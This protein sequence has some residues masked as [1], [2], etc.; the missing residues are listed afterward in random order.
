[1][2]LIALEILVLPGTTIAG[3][4]GGI[5]LA[6]GLGMALIGAGATA[7]AFLV[8][9]GRVAASILLAV[10]GAF[11][12]LRV[13]PRLPFG[14]RLVLES[15]MPAELGYVSG[16]ESDHRWR[17]RVG[18]AVSPLRP[19]GIAE[20]DGTRVD[21]VSD[22]SFIEAGTAIE[23]TRVDGNRIVVRQLSPLQE[24]KK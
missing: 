19:A 2:L 12:L 22:G 5:A 24:H 11:A 7:S 4:A 8:A 3:I 20:I 13:L 1:V 18:V 17:G 21:V 16:P 6:A 14:R 23:V 9:L 10:V 15:G